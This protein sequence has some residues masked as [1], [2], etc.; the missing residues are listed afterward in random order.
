MIIIVSCVIV[1]FF[2]N[3]ASRVSPKNLS[4]TFQCLLWTTFSVERHVGQCS[5]S[6]L[7]LLMSLFSG[8]D[9]GERRGRS[10]CFPGKCHAHYGA[11]GLFNQRALNEAAHCW[12][13]SASAVSQPLRW[14]QTCRL[15]SGAASWRRPSPGSLSS[16]QS[17]F[18]TMSISC[19]RHTPTLPRV[20]YK[21]GKRI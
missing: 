16:A 14:R 5:A 8:F 15:L 9:E 2:P 21:G 10:R 3:C 4:A 18:P 7:Y 13:A 20:D 19:R 17:S 12:S 6:A 11:R 1:L